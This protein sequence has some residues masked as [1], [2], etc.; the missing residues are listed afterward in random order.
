MRIPYTFFVAQYSVNTRAHCS[1]V[2]FIVNPA[3]GFAQRINFPALL[4]RH[5]D[6]S[7]IHDRVVQTRGPG[8]AFDLASAAVAEGYEGVVSIGGDGTV[9]E[10]GRAL[11]G[12]PTKLGIIPVGSGNGLARHLGIPLRP[13]WAVRLL[14]NGR[15]LTIDSGSVNGQPFFCTMGVG[16]DAEVAHAFATGPRRGFGQ[17]LRIGWRAFRQ[18]R[19]MRQHFE[20]DGCRYEQDAFVMTIA[21]A[22]QYGNNAHI[23]P[24]AHIADGWLDLCWLAPFPVW[25]AAD[26]VRRLFG[27]SLPAAPHYGTQRV[28][29]LCLEA[30]SGLFYHLDGEPLRAEG[31]LQIAV[32]PQSLRVV[33]PFGS[34]GP[35]CS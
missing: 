32:H 35:R 24:Q 28:R 6:R 16:F 2:L 10:V 26:Y 15:S 34:E 25:Q 22:S 3:S 14:T 20:A 33:V 13:A 23:A 19:P 4:A 1:R 21:N 11:L 18:H 29:R 9:N 17:Y 31:P 5:L 8:H 30:E 7:R 12:T 27:D